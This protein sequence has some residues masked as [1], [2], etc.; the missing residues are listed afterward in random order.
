MIHN[1]DPSKMLVNVN[2]SRVK[3]AVIVYKTN[4]KLLEVF[5]ETNSFCDIACTPT[6]KVYLYKFYQQQ[7]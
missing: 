3:F 6:V 4:K 2:N 1:S 7:Q 5:A